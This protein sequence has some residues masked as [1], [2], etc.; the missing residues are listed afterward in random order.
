MIAPCTGAISK[1]L[2]VTKAFEMNMMVSVYLL[3]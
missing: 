3:G 2:G 1:S